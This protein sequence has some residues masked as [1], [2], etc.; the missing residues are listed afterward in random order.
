MNK[1]KGRFDHLI[2]NLERISF[3]KSIFNYKSGRKAFLSLEQGNLQEWLETFLPNTRLI[4]EPKIIGSSIGIQY[5]NG[6]LNKAINK[7][8]VNITQEVR[9]LRSIAKRIPIKERIEIRGVLYHYEKTSAENN[10]KEFI[11]L[12]QVPTNQKGLRFCA[13]HIFH[14]NINQFQA[15]QELKKLNFEVPKTQFTRFVSDIDI[16]HQ[17]WKEGKLFKSYPTNGIVLKINSRKFQKQL[18]ENNISRHW[19][20]AMN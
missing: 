12:K 15:H 5:I 13:F 7:N 2:M 20:F 16:Y 18:G 6:K 19:A 3:E 1:Y 11:E 10:N 9:S 4:L 17:C 8:S 14:C